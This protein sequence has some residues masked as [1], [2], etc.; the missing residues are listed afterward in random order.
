[1]EVH[2]NIEDIPSLRNPVIT[3]G[4]FDGVH[5]GHQQIILRLKEAAREIDGESV[6]L[7]FEPH[8]KM[9]LYPDSDDLQLINTLDEKISLLELYEVDHLIIMPFTQSFAQQP[10]LR[11]IEDFLVK[12]LNP[13]K[14]VIGY[15]HRFGREREGDIQ[16][17]KSSSEQY[18][19]QVEEIPKQVVDDVSVSSTKIR[20][21]ISQGDMKAANQLLGHRFFIMGTVVKG[22]QVGQSLGFPTANIRI[23]DPHKI[24]PANGVYAVEVTHGD[25]ILKGMLNIGYR[26]TLNGIQTEKSIEV[27]IFDFDKTIYSESLKIEFIAS[28]RKERKFED[29]D[30]LKE[31]LKLDKE[32]T[33][34]LLK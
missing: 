7:T 15:N 19:F 31:Q 23:D 2:R 17:L 28:I 22:D 33:L 9:V 25:K 6:I 24:L 4:T 8:P 20:K 13:K 5:K 14:I 21:A 3:I 12:K 30:E 26:P 32:T 18:G 34:R 29:L 16:L 11:Y 1:M 27:N 10:P